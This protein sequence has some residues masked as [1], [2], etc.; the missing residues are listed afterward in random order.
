MVSV[1]GGNSPECRHIFWD[2]RGTCLVSNSPR[3]CLAA[4]SAIRAGVSAGAFRADVTVTFTGKRPANVSYPA[5]EFCGE[6]VVRQ[7]GVPA[8]LVE[9]AE[10]RYFQTDHRFPD[11]CLRVPDPQSNKGDMGKLLMVC[12]SWGMAGACVMAA[13][14]ALRCGV[15]LLQILVGRAALSHSFSSW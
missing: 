6:T 13:K 11:Q 4:W 8:A 12:G 3:T 10:T 2:T 7:V 1:S 14:A 5:K 15:G 9:G